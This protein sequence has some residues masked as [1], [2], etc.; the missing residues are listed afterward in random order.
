MKKVLFVATV[1][2]LHIM[3]FHIPYLE[4][5]K[6][7]GYEVHVAARNDY[8]NKEECN[9]PFCDKLFDLPFERSPIKKNNFYVYKELKNI[10]DINEYEIIH[11]HTPMGGAI[12]RLA[13]RSA[14]KSGTKVI[15]TA[16]GFH[17]YKGAPLINWLIYYPVEKWLARYTDTLITINKEDYERAKSKFRAKR[18]LY[19]PG[20][21]IDLEKFNTV[22]LDRDLKR[23][24]LGLP[25]DALVVLSVGEL[26]KNKNHEVIIRAI[27]KIN[28]TNIHYIICGQGKLDEHLW[29]LSIELGLENQ[30][31]L[32]GF[33]KDIPEICMISELF[34]FPSYR[35]GLSVALMEA[36]ANGLPVVCSNIRGNSDLTESGKGGYLVEPDNVEGFA[37]HIKE[38]IEDS[39]LRSELGRFNHKKI[40]NYSIENV[41]K[42]MEKIYKDL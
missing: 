24:E 15:Y 19:I 29:N 27:A 39:R 5:F 41:L 32:L 31:H 7:N 14:R 28:N 6:K 33:R 21:G 37:K 18:V 20:V 13:A 25:K 42:E 30:V 17:F 22:E 8:E 11:C 12:G 34:A 23:S 4:W 35:E 10:I 16:H 38:L 36:M 1:V 3:V 26:N 40:E 2:K 9:V